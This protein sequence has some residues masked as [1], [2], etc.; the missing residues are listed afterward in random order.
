[1]GNESALRLVHNSHLRE[2]KGRRQDR[3]RGVPNYN[4]DLTKS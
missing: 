1:M 2:E 4:V 3:A